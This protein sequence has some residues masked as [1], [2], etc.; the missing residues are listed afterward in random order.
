MLIKLSIQEEFCAGIYSLSRPLRFENLPVQCMPAALALSHSAR[1]NGRARQSK[2]D[3]S[4][5]VQLSWSRYIGPEDNPK[6]RFVSKEIA[7]EKP[8]I[9]KS[10]VN[11]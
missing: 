10:A 9:I 7:M 8:I 11:F 6:I 5:P 3:N 2:T 1:P 4:F